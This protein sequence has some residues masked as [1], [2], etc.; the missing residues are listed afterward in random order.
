MRINC[1][2]TEAH[3]AESLQDREDDDKVDF[4]LTLDLEH[5]DHEDE[6]ERR[7]AAHDDKL[8]DDVRE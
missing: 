1:R 2:L 8:C 7:L 6:H 5:D 4:S 3:S